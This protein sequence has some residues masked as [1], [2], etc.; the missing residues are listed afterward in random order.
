M[1]D[2]TDQSITE[3]PEF[4]KQAERV[5][6]ALDPKPEGEKRTVGV[7]EIDVDRDD[8]E[9]PDVDDQTS[10]RDWGWST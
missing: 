10:F 1:I 5:E 4:E 9:R 2:A 7:P 6:Y 3:R 8:I